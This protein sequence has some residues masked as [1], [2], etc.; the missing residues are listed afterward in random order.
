[1]MQTMLNPYE[2]TKIAVTGE[3][4]FEEII[5]ENL[6]SEDEVQFGDCVINV[7]KKMAFML[8]NNSNACIR[9]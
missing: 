3:S 1:M 9:F 8:R 7:E 4:F 5:F 6:A 2:V